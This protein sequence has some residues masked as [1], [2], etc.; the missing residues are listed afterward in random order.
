LIE[1]DDVL[2]EILTRLLLWT[3]PGALPRVIDTEAA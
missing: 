3:D 2:A 1:N